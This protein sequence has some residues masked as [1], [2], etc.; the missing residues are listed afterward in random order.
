[1][2]A[3]GYK[4]LEEVPKAKTNTTYFYCNAKDSQGKGFVSA[5]GFTV[6]KG[7]TVSANLA[8]SFKAHV[9]GYYK[10]RNELENNGTIVNKTFQCDYEFNAPSAAAAVITGRSSNG[11]LEWKTENGTTLKDFNM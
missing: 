5:G 4:L 2:S 3:L 11:T 9:V 6:L 8:P 10:L 1:M 7:S